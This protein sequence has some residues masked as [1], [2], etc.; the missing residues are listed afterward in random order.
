MYKVFINKNTLI[1]T[2]KLP[3]SD[4]K[5]KYFTYSDPAQLIKL[6][7]GLEAQNKRK[8]HVLYH[9]DLD[10]LWCAFMGSFKYVQAAGG[11][12]R[13]PDTGKYLLIYR[14]DRWDLPKGHLKKG[15]RPEFAAIREVE[16]EC[17][18]NGIEVTAPLAQ[19]F[20]M[21]ER[22][23][24]VFLKKTFWYRMLS[25]YDG[26]L[27][28][29]TEEGIAKA[30]WMEERDFSDIKKNIYPLIWGLLKKAVK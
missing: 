9:Y 12:V 24:K 8:R 28:P 23:G 4:G 19:T 2:D 18:I 25:R 20:H 30:V 15:E 27:V 14:N 5:G 11:L 21:Y 3:V 17:G 13:N 10:E 16:E 22:K 29:Q 7:A 1:L 26:T 6:V